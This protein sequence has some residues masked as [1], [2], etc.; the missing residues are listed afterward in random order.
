MVKISVALTTVGK[1]K[2][3]ERIAKVLIDRRVAAC[4]NIIPGIVSHYCWQGKKCRDQE[5]LLLMKTP[6]SKLKLLEKTLLSLHPYDVP[7]FIHWPIEGGY[8]QYLDW[9]LDRQTKSR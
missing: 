7:E 9:V 5:F 3:A 4:V 2:D 8:K 6:T 1:R